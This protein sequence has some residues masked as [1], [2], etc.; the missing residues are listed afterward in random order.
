MI[1]KPETTSDHIAAEKAQPKMDYQA[2]VRSFGIIAITLLVGVVLSLLSPYFLTAE[3][4]LNVIRQSSFLLLIAIGQTLVI[5]TAGIDLSVSS[6][7]SISG[8][9]TTF[10][11]LKGID[12]NLA[13]LAGVVSGGLVGVLN[14]FLITIGRMEPFLATLSTQIIGAGT[15]LYATQGVPIVPFNNDSF[16]FLGR[17]YLGWL[18][19]PILVVAVVAIL[20][21]FMV[22]HTVFGRHLYAVG[23]NPKAAKVS[24]IDV[25]R[26]ISWAYVISGL[27]AGL[28]GVML[29]SRLI[30]GQPSAGVGMELNSIAAAVVGGASFFGGEGTIYG[31]VAGVILIGIIGN[32]LNLLNVS[33]FLHQAVIGSVIVFAVVLDRQMKKRRT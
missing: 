11:L 23:G 20:A 15:I 16:S 1:N 22:S 31:T 21:H 28:A 12:L 6:V 8:C 18:P 30:S 3:N 10:L 17:G 7:I 13:F 25:D 14:A 33:S 27:L 4:I 24:G 26:M 29:A 2:F 5:I 9:L 19:V 32:G